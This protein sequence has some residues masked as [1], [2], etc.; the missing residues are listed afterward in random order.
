MLSMQRMNIKRI[1]IF[2]IVV[3]IVSFQLVGYLLGKIT[4]NN[5]VWYHDL[6]K[7]LLTPL[8]YLF[9]IIWSLLY[10]IISI[11][12]WFLLDNKGK[13]TSKFTLPTYILHILLN[14]S[15][16]PIFFGLHYIGLSLICIVLM[17]LTTIMTIITVKPNYP[18]ISLALTP[19]FCWQI[20]AAYLNLYIVIYN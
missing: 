15:W 3:Y 4:R 14:W 10:F 7:F 6:N 9:P 5:M 18:L 1:K 8:T 13:L 16:T 19:Y 17:I 2:K 11:I 20:F 12:L